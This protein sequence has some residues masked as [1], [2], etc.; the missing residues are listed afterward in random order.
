[1]AGWG[2]RCQEVQ[3]G[4]SSVA[5]AVL[6]EA[7]FD[8]LCKSK[9][10]LFGRLY[11]VDSYE[12]ARPDA[13]CSLCCAWGHIAPHCE[14]ATPRFVCNLVFDIPLPK[15]NRR[16]FLTNLF[17]PRTSLRR[18]SE[19]SHTPPHVRQPPPGVQS[20]PRT[21]LQ[22]TVG[23][24]SRGVGW[25][26]VARVPTGRPSALTAGS[27]WGAGRCLCGQEDGSPAI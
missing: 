2:A 11:E 23:A 27:P 17:L 16:A 25:E 10:R 14:A 6:G 24:P 7:V 18:H 4:T 21:I 1:M 9:A 19:A 13:F 20:A 12:E 5:A 15:G 26:R 22:T 8:R 3:G